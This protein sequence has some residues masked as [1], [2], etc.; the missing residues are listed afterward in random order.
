MVDQSRIQR[1]DAIRKRGPT[2]LRKAEELGE[3]ANI[4]TFAFYQALNGRLHV[5]FFVPENEQVPTD[6]EVLEALADARRGIS[7]AGRRTH[8]PPNGAI[9]SAN[10]ALRSNTRRPRRGPSQPARRVVA[11]ECA[12]SI[13]VADRDVDEGFDRGGPYD[14]PE[15]TDDDFTDD[16]SIDMEDISKEHVDD[17]E[18]VSDA[19]A[20]GTSE[21]SGIVTE[22]IATHIGSG[23][24]HTQGGEGD[25]NF[26]WLPSQDSTLYLNGLGMGEGC[27]P[28][29]SA[30]FPDGLQSSMFDQPCP[31]LIS[32][33]TISPIIYPEQ[34]ANENS[35]EKELVRTRLRAYC[36]TR[37]GMS[38][39]I[40]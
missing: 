13:Q 21:A 26:E 10:I 23:T 4:C 24:E 19:S 37:L 28:E 7:R 14:V 6:T 29:F 32:M 3:K 11:A 1:T 5:A 18:V 8:R 33:P 12:N 27:L 31:D 30:S 36:H 22:P 25:H 35:K 15:S 2:L 40:V 9:R 39:D 17:D 34:P 38:L 20:A 16:E